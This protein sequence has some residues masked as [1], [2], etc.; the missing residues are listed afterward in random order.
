VRAGGERA[1]L[2]EPLSRLSRR[3]LVA[4]AEYK[5][6]IDVGGTDSGRIA[7]ELPPV[8]RPAHP[9]H[10]TQR[11]KDR[12]EAVDR[13]PQGVVQASLADSLA[14]AARLPQHAQDLQRIEEFRTG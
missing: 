14:G 6:A 3:E 7:A 5:Q 2:S 13:Q 4:R 8:R 12:F 9:T 1:K 10:G 11:L